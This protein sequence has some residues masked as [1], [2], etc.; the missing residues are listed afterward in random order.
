MDFFEILKVIF[1]GIVEGITEWLPISSTGHM[2]LVEQLMPLKVSKEFMEMFR[3]VIQLG[4]ILAVLVLYWNKIFPFQLKNKNKP[5]IKWDIMNMWFKIVVAVLP[6]GVI[7][8]LYDDKIDALFYNYITVAITLIVYGVLFIFIEKRN[9][10]GNFRITSLAEITYQTAIIIGIFQVLSLIPGTSRSGATILGAILIGVSR[11][12]AAEFT[13]FLAIPVMFGASL[14][15]MLKFG[16]NYTTN[17]VLVMILGMLS[18]FIVSILA[19]KFLMGYIKKHD[20]KAFGIYRIVLGILVVIYFL[21]V[22]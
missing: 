4:A 16:L 2:I 5:F 19:I 12:V 3:V 1:Y 7:G 13:F 17:E 15:K 9:S 21:V 14:I 8:I 22:H 20:F 11:S 10:R 18:A 6:A